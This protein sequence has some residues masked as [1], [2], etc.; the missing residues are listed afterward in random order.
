MPHRN[1]GPR[2]RRLLDSANDVTIADV[3]RIAGNNNFCAFDD[4]FNFKYSF[5]RVLRKY[6]KMFFVSLIGV[7]KNVNEKGVFMLSAI[8]FLSGFGFTWWGVAFAQSPVLSNTA[9]FAMC[10][11]GLIYSKWKPLPVVSVENL[12]Q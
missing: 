12:N 3:V 4:F 8:G 2:M 11:L 5:H 9:G 7:R 6:R 10:L 1:L